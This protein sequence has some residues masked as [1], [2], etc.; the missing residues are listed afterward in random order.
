MP[1]PPNYTDI[2]DDLEAKI[3]GGTYPPGSKL[4]TGLELAVKCKAQP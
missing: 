4:P 3:H 1:K 2:A